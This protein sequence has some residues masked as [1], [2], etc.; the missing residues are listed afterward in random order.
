MAGE[1]LGLLLTAHHGDDQAETLLMRLNRGSGVAG[2]AG[3]RAAGPVPGDDSGLRLCRP[4]LGW[5]RRELE[6]IVSAAGIEPAQDPSNSDEAFDRARLR[7]RMGEAR[8]LDPAALARSAALLAEAE[9]ALEWSAGRLFRERAETGER[10]VALNPH[11]LP[12]ELLR[13]LVLRCLRRV[14]PGAAPRGEQLMS[15]IARLQAGGTATLGGVK[16]SSGEIW[17]FEIAPP[18]RS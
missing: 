11:D 14:R 4:L 7:R 18:R 13:R 2:L 6:A 10:W 15:L 9:A 1:G 3:V 5:R 16:A 17:R 12:P 8:W